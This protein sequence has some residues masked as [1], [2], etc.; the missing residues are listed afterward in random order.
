[1]AVLKPSVKSHDQGSFSQ[2]FPTT[3]LF[4]ELEYYIRLSVISFRATGTYGDVR[5]GLHP[6]LADQLTLFQSEV[7]VVVVVVVG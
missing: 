6:F 4:L 1:M 3:K 5:T 7:V 2:L